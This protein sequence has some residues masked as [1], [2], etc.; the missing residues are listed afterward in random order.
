MKKKIYHI[1]TPAAWQAAQ[2]AGE[3]RA[4]SLETEGFIHCSRFEQVT[5]TAGRHYAGQRGLVV[6]ELDEAALGNTVK[7]EMAPIGELF[8][9]IYGPIPVKV[10]LS[11][12][13]LILGPDGV[14]SFPMHLDDH[15]A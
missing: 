2:Q 10:V 7:Y 14:F 8:P 6:L 5:P 11:V 4:D 3:Y 9:H 15:E 12:A 13:P 1:T